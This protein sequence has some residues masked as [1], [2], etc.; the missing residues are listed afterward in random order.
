MLSLD[1]A[2]SGL[3]VSGQHDGSAPGM[4]GAGAT[5]R[6]SRMGSS[7]LPGFYKMKMAERLRRLAA[8]LELDAD[9]LDGLG[10]TATLPLANAE[11]MIENAVG[12]LGLPVRLRV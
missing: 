12:V 3:S 2:V 5:W 1:R 7:R 8:E 6:S 4:I 10:E 9:D 11:A